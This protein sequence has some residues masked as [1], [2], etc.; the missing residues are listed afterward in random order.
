[1]M[2]LM[3]GLHSL[4]GNKERARLIIGQR[5]LGKTVLLLELADY[6]RKNDYIVASPTVVTGGMLDR[7]MEKLEKDG[8]KEFARSKAKIT[9]GSVGLFGFSAGIQTEMK[10][11]PKR[12][13]A[14][15]LSEFCEKANAIGKGVLILVDEVQANNAELKQLI[16]AYQEM[17]GEG[18]NIAVV[19]AG[20][21]IAIA[22]TLNEHVLTFFNRAARLYLE[23][24][25]IS[26]IEIYFRSSF[27]KLKLKVRDKWIR[28][29]AEETGGSPYMMQ[30]TGHYITVS[31]SDE[32]ELEKNAFVRALEYAKKEFVTD[33]CETTLAPLSEKDMAFLKAMSSD[34]RE[35]AVKALADRL[36]VD[37]AYI[38]RYKTRLIQ[39]GIIRQPRRGYVAYA[40]PYL[41]EYFQNEKMA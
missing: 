34:D 12:S 10:E 2:T 15:R 29:A 25:D 16:I 38:Q 27:E 31:A 37:A 3:E 24:I 14:Y 9:G 5:G 39:S 30:L 41:Q 26:E 20:L 23:P 35:S 11:E 7:I 8:E 1:M 22:K 17:V 40:V 28:Q 21:P 36:R 13:F 4:P 6:A 33:I 32:G 19:F 18:R